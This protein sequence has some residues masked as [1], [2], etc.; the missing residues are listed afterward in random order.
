[1]NDKFKNICIIL[2]TIIILN[3]LCSCEE[4]KPL[5]YFDED[6]PA[7]AMID[8]TTVLV[9][10]LAGKAILKYAVP[11][12]ENLLYVKAVCEMSPGVERSAQSSRFVDTLTLEG[13]ADAG[14]FPVNLYTVGKNGKKSEP[15]VVTVS[16]HT[17][18]LIE[19][20]PSLNMIATFGGIEGHFENLYKETLKVVLM[21]DTA[22]TG[23]RTF[24]QS[25]VINNPNA[26]FSIRDL[27]SKPGKFYVYLMDRWG[28]KTDSKEYVLTPLFEKKLDKSLWKE[29]KLPSDFKNTLE[30]NF[31]GYQ[32][33]GLFDNT[34]CP[35]NG[36][37]NT[38]IPEVRPLPSFFTIDLGITAKISRFNLVPF[39]NYLYRDYPRTFEVYGTTSRN[40]G[41]DLDGEEWKL[42]G[43]YESYKPSG[44]DPSVITAED[45]AFLW[46]N[47]ENFDVKPSD[48][49][50]DPYF[51]VR[52]IRFKITSLWHEEE[53]YSYDELTIWG[54]EVEE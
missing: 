27:P 51:P 33:T 20:F 32:F 35:I 23:E 50:L 15:L 43:K 9:E 17:P 39:W 26:V 29:N 3:I 48:F 41:D 54:E 46:P 40:P 6:A 10:N 11:N 14:D 12:D 5:V 47:G 34:I 8:V 31:W 19:A 38:F 16:P 30:N 2:I 36:W 53:R 1:M 7:P 22:N 45:R 28:N 52:M 18:P 44:P 25:F 13:F 21:A 4:S 24:L 42:I 49:Q 37:Q